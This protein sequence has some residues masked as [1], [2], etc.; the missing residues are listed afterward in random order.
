MKELKVRINNVDYFFEKK[1]SCWVCD[2]GHAYAVLT[3]DANGC[4]M[5]AYHSPTGI[6]ISSDFD[7]D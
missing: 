5:L 7:I 1:K 3:C 6:K 2:F 4:Y